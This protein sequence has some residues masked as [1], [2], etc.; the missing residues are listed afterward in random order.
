M[1]RVLFEAIHDTAAVEPFLIDAK[2]R[3]AKVALVLSQATD[4]HES[5]LQ[6]KKGDDPFFARCKNAPATIEQTLCRK[7]QQYLYLA[8]R[9]AGHDVDLLTEDD[10][11]A[12]R[13]AGY[14]SCIFAGEWVQRRAVKAL[15]DWVTAGGTLFACG[16]LGHR[17]EFDE[18]DPAML[19]LL[20]L[21]SAAT[22]KALIAPRTLLELPLAEPI[23]QI[24]AGD[25]GVPFFGLRQNLEP[26]TAT[27]LHRWKEGQAA[28]TR[29][30]HGKG[31][32]V[33]VGGLPGMAWIR[34]GL[35]PIPYARG[36]RGTFYFPDGYDPRAQD[37]A[38]LGIKDGHGTFSASAGTGV[39]TLVLDSKAGTLVTLVNW[40]DTPAKDR[41]VRVRVP[42]APKVVRDITTG[43]ELKATYSDGVATFRLDVADATFVTLS[44]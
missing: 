36:G 31:S 23:G 20:G 38:L 16:G 37:L 21:K 40:R 12:G 24:V 6:R 5:R 44:R 4:Y 10:V 22:T 30:K 43:K 35:K 13:L 34:S 29:Q 19:A 1:Y 14:E 28:V 11:I 8:L 27:V 3:K 17:N 9:E 25:A 33:A 32:A 26:G 2:R 15:D 39:E 42:F 41:E 7:E 18:A